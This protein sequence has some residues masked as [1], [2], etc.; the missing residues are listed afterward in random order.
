MNENTAV[1]NTFE[2]IMEQNVNRMTMASF[3]AISFFLLIG[4]RNNVVMVLFLNSPMISL[5]INVEANIINVALI[6]ESIILRA[7]SNF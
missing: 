7:S 3:A 6:I 2:M 5:E 1:I 4:Y